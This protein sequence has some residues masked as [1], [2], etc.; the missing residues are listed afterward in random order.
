MRW[1]LNYF[2]CRD[3]SLRD[4]VYIDA[5]LDKVSGEIMGLLWEVYS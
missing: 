4:L 1:V 2:F 5:D 3:L